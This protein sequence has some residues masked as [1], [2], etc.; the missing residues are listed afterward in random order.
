MIPVAV[1]TCLVIA[2]LFW[3]QPWNGDLDIPT[4]AAELARH[5]NQRV[6]M[7]IESGSL[8]EIRAYLE[9][10]DFPL[11]ESSRY[12][13]GEWEPAGGRYCSLKGNPAAQLRLRNRNTERTLTFYQLLVPRSM[14]G[15]EGAFEG[16]EQGVKVEI[17]TER[18]LLLAVA[19]DD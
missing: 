2:A 4:L 13:D 9:R 5:H 10:L 18:G 11:I 12:P 14:A 16:Y 3:R 19:R 1:L 15:F 6:H 7:E 17:W 8:A